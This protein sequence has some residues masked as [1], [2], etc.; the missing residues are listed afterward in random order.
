MS[1]TIGDVGCD[2]WVGWETVDAAFSYNP[3]IACGDF[4][5]VFGE[6]TMWGASTDG[7]GRAVIVD[8]SE[9]DAEDAEIAEFD[10]PW[11]MSGVARVA[12]A[13]AERMEHPNPDN[14]IGAARELWFAL[15]QGKAV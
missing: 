12:R 10:F 2:G 3:T 6:G 9:D 8:L 11:S 5:V 15:F 13:V 7:H 1:G 4:L 14:V